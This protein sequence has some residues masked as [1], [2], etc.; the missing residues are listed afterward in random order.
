MSISDIYLIGDTTHRQSQEGLVHM[1]QLKRSTATLI[2]LE[3]HRTIHSKLVRRA[4]QRR[5]FID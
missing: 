5:H 4:Q 1:I 2:V 3:K